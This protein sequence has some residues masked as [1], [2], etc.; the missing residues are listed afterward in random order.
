M[1]D[2]GRRTPKRSSKALVPSAQARAPKGTTSSTRTQR[3]CCTGCVTRCACH[4]FQCGDPAHCPDEVRARTRVELKL[5]PDV[6]AA[7]AQDDNGEE[8]VLNEREHIP[9]C[10]SLWAFEPGAFAS[11]KRLTSAT[12]THRK[13]I[14]T[15]APAAAAPNAARGGMMWMPVAVMPSPLAS[16]FMIEDIRVIPPARAIRTVYLIPMVGDPLHCTLYVPSTRHKVVTRQVRTGRVVAWQ[17]KQ[18]RARRVV[19]PVMR[20][21]TTTA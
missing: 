10:Q 18:R 8:V 7:T 21:H 6:E 9:L 16:N 14:A 13:T 5:P 19:A 1:A 2:L 4:S 15:L 11:S 3:F 12:Q 20:T 17:R